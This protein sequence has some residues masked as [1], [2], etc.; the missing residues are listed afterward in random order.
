M[1][2]WEDFARGYRDKLEDLDELVEFTLMEGDFGFAAFE[3]LEEAFGNGVD[4]SDEW[5]AKL[6][7]SFSQ[8][9]V[10]GRETS[11]TSPRRGLLMLA[12]LPSS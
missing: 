8:R 12:V 6:R 10:G 11:I 4:I 1:A 9:R 5:L 2:I 7:E 3:V